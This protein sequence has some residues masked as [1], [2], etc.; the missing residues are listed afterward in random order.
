MVSKAQLIPF[1]ISICLMLFL[2][3]AIFPLVLFDR[4]YACSRGVSKYGIDKIEDTY[5]TNP[6][7]CEYRPPPPAG[8]DH[9]EFNKKYNVTIHKYF[10]GGHLFIAIV[11]LLVYEIALITSAVTLFRGNPATDITRFFVSFGSILFDFILTIVV[12]AF[13][14]QEL[15]EL[16]AQLIFV[17]FF[18]IPAILG[19]CLYFW[20]L[21]RSQH[22]QSELEEKTREVDSKLPDIYGGAAPDRIRSL[23]TSLADQ[24]SL[25]TKFLSTGI[26]AVFR[27]NNS[28]TSSLATFSDDT[29]TFTASTADLLRR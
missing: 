27:I 12:F 6:L 17:A 3:S 22:T 28:L 10:N 11:L 14:L 4:G 26:P 20:I 7:Y 18:T 29:V 19:C 24:I 21:Y 23:M 2:L 9:K 15:V 16:D 13:P 5:M 1:A 25:S 8:V